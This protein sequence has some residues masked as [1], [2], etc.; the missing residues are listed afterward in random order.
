MNHNSRS[1]VGF[2][3]VFALV[4]TILLITTHAQTLTA[5]LEQEQGTLSGN[6]TTGSDSTASN[7]AYVQ[8]GSSSTGYVFDDEFSGSS[9]D[10]SLWL[11]NVGGS[12]SNGE[13]ECFQPANVNESGGFLT[14]TA[15]VD[16]SCSGYSYTSGAIQSKFSFTSGTVDVRAKLSG[17]TGTWPAIWLLG[18][19]C[20]PW[21]MGTGGCN[22]AWPQQ[23]SDESDIAEILYNNHTSVNEQLH[24]ASSGSACSPSVSDV[25]QNFHTYTL[26][27]TP[28]S[29][30]WKIDGITTCTQ[31][32]GVPSDRM[33]LIINT[34]VGGIGG[35]S[36]NNST[37][38]QTTT[39][40][41]VHISS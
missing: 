23:G 11:V 20:Q 7:N 25:T 30:I 22:P 2:C 19:G 21:R 32:S 16:N 18:T 40:D 28:G 15:K 13:L 41:Y 9:V 3:L 29:M 37:L 8:F 1:I 39:V 24:T 5:S 4:G 38:P 17:G 14:E 31:T 6:V 34:S 33:F 26:V 36:V 27:W 12:S 10:T 35:G